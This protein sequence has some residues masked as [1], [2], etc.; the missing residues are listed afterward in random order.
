MAAQPDLVKV[1]HTLRQG[2]A[3]A[4][5]RVQVTSRDGRRVFLDAGRKRE[6]R[7]TRRSG[8]SMR[9]ISPGVLSSA[10]LGSERN[11][12]SWTVRVGVA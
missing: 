8:L 1:V 3:L 10:L 5:R 9:A 7:G 6:A 2:D 12:V 4:A 11:R